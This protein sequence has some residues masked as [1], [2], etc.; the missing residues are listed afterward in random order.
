MDTEQKIKTIFKV[1]L[2]AYAIYVGTQGSPL[3]GF[4]L[5]SISLFYT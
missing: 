5:L 1:I 3:L 2:G 4:A